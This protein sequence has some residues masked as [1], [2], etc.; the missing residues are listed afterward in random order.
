[1]FTESTPLSTE[2][3]KNEDQES[4]EIPQ[5]QQGLNIFQTAFFMIGNVAGS[6]I[7]VL[8]KAIDY[9]GCIGLFLM[10][11]AAFAS[12]YNGI[13][14]GQCW[15][16]VR[17]RYRHMDGYVQDPYAAIA[18]AAFGSKMGILVSL[19]GNI[20]LFGVAVVF[21]LMSSQNLQSL[22]Q[23]WFNL[24]ISF[25]YWIL[26]LGTSLI[27]A[28]WLGSPKNFKIFGIISASTIFLACLIMNC[29]F[30][31]Q[32]YTKK[33]ETVYKPPNPSKLIFSFGVMMYSFSGTVTFP[34]IQQDMKR[35]EKFHLSAWVSYTT[36]LAMYMTVSCL[37]YL[38]VGSKLQVNVLQN[39][40]INWF[41]YIAEILITIHLV[42]ALIS[43]TNP[44]FQSIEKLFCISA[45]FGWKRCVA[46][47]TLMIIIIFIA[48]SIPNFSSLLSLVAACGTF[49]TFIAPCLFYIKIC[50]MEGDWPKEYVYN[51]G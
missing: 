36:I 22:L 40:A 34:T 28:C 23:H 51:S 29:A 11:V 38:S 17:R 43:N 50:S 20:F 41:R 26:I 6:G 35:P 9:A 7:L 10:I 1:M 21:V 39:I 44:L 4:K 12:G 32:I 42:F 33:S 25:C 47:T 45:E 18:K 13:R 8:P 5:V 30:I 27:P 48:E 16:I 31:A 19:M 49:L 46:R 3:N 24:R 37:G 14:L 2:K 15:T